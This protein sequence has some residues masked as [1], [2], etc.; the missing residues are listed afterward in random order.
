[1]AEREELYRRLASDR[2]LLATRHLN[3]LRERTTPSGPVTDRALPRREH[4]PFVTVESRAAQKAKSAKQRALEQKERAGRRPRS[5]APIRSIRCP[6]KRR[7]LPRLQG[8]ARRRSRGPAERLT[9][10]KYIRFYSWLK[11][12]RFTN[13]LCSAFLFLGFSGTSIMIQ[14]G[15]SHFRCFQYVHWSLLF[16]C[17]FSNVHFPQKISRSRI[18]F[19]V[20]FCV[21]SFLTLLEYISCSSMSLVHLRVLRLCYLLFFKELESEYISLQNI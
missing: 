20:S 1:M 17:W 3:E 15:N 21:P 5:R 13:T 7:S 4:D 11:S 16:I 18:H 10:S 9:D 14:T 12:S 8:A 19:H 2:Q 6:I